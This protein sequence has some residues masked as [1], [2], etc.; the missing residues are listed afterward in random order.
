M[1][2]KNFFWHDDLYN[3]GVIKNLVGLEDGS[4]DEVSNKIRLCELTGSCQ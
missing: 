4:L 1:V 2:K 3:M